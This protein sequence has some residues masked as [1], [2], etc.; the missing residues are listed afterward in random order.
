MEVL[1][2]INDINHMSMT[3]TTNTK[4]HDTYVEEADTVCS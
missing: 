1:F 2:L 3:T 4:Q